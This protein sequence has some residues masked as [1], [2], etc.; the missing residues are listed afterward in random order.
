MFKRSS[1]SSS[2]SQHEGPVAQAQLTQP[3]KNCKK[4]LD[5]TQPVGRPYPW[6]NPTHG[7]ICLIYYA[8]L[9]LCNKYNIAMTLIILTII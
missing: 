7:Q 5:P 3:T 9:F 8:V 6:V 1:S 4:N 2:A